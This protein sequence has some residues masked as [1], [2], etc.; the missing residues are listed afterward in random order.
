[1]KETFK[2]FKNIQTM[3]FQKTVIQS[4]FKWNPKIRQ[5]GYL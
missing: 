1:M 2:K 5:N 4:E 3:K